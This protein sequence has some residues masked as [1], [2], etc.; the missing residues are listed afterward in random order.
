M[1]VYFTLQKMGR[2]RT[3]WD[4]SNNNILSSDKYGH[5]LTVS[6]IRS[7]A[8]R[9]SENDNEDA[10]N[11]EESLEESFNFNVFDGTP[12]PD[13]PWARFFDQGDQSDDAN[14]P[15]EGGQPLP[16]QGVELVDDKNG[17]NISDF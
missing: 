10:T 6:D 8:Q 9:R 5:G 3:K 2:K 17:V 1:V 13:S 7:N 15:G 12:D 4:Y 11:S 14:A 16:N